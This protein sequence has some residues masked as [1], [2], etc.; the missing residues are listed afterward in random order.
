M[1]GKKVNYTPPPVQKDDSFEKYLQYQQQ[2]ETAAEQRVATEKAEQ[3]AADDARKAS[4]AAGYGGLRTGV[5]NQLRQG[6]IGYEDATRQLRDYATKY[7]MTPP[8][9]DVT[10]LT[11]VYTQELLPGRR[12]TSIDSAYQEI[13]GRAPTEEEKTSQ[14][15]KFDQQYYTSNDDLRNALYK[16]PEYTKKYNDN[17]LDNYFDTQF[18]SSV[19]ARTEEYTDATTGEKKT[20]VTKAR[21]FNFDP[22]LLPSYSDQAG[23]EKKTGVTQPDYAK[24]FSQG[25]SIEELQQ[26]LQGVKDTRQYLYSAGLTNLQ[27]E[28]D[29]ETQKLKNEGAKELAKVQSQG[30]IYNSLVGSFNF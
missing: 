19:E 21:K 5:E 25:R 27:G 28:I 9:A 6:L 4:G 8:E 7:D 18:G 29:K 12:K 3:K 13:L 15:Q 26:G 16:A 2:K 1:G 11:N 20:K 14:L 17:Y 22:S 10:N 30:S 24:Y 23:L